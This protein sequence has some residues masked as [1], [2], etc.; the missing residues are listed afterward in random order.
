MRLFCRLAALCCW[1]VVATGTATLV[2]ADPLDWP[3]WRGPNHNGTSQETGLIDSWDPETGENVVWTR[4]DLSARSTPIVMNGK[5]YIQTRANPAT[6]IEGERVVCLDAATGKTLWENTFG[7]Y[8]SDVPDTRVGWPSVTGDPETG[9]VYAQGVCGVFL[10]IDGETGKTL[11]SR[12]MHEEFGLLSTYGGRTNTPVVFEDLVIASGVMIGWREFAVPAHRF[13]AFDKRTGEI[14]WTNG[15]ALSPP[16]T[17]YSMPVICKLAGQDA[18]V[19]GSSDGGVHAFQPRTGKEIWKYG[20]SRRGLN[21]TPTVHDGVVYIGH[22]EE[23]WNEND[24]TMGSI[25]AIDGTLRG[26]IT[27]NGAKWRHTEVV[28]GRSSPLVIDDKVYLIDDRGGL[29]IFDAETGKQP[30]LKGSRARYDMK[31]GRGMFG[32]PLYADG[33]I[34]LCTTSGEWWILKPDPKKGVEVVQ[35]MLRLNTEVNGSPIVSH[36][37]IYLATGDAIYCLGK[38]DAPAAQQAAA[39]D[40][41][42]DTKPQDQTPAHVQVS[43]ADVLLAP[44]QS[45]KFTVR[46]YNAAGELLGESKAD[47]SVDRG[48]SVKA[49]GTYTADKDYTHQASVV[50]AKVGDLSGSARIRVIGDLPW[51]F[52]FSDGRV[53]EVWVGMRNRHIVVDFDLVTSLRASDHM[54]HELYLYFSKAFLDSGRSSLSYTATSRPTPFLSMLKFLN[55]HGQVNTQPDAQSRLNDALDRLVQ[56]KVLA[57]YEWVG[58]DDAPGLAVEK[59]PRQIEN[60]VAI[61]LDRIPIPSGFTQLGTR[62][63]G[64]M[65]PIDLHDYTV[66]ADF[67]G[68]EQDGKL[69]SFG[70]NNQRYQVELNGPS[71]ILEIRTWFAQKRMANSAP[72]QW[73]ANTWYRIKMQSE[74]LDDRVVLRAKVWPRDSEEPAEWTVTAEDLAP[75]RIGAPGFWGTAQET[76]YYLDNVKVYKNP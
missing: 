11:W 36:G 60:A 18:M 64:W 53:P 22:G 66:E 7:V 14:R 42:D 72:Y 46:L 59:G 62:S 29:W 2:A 76:E 27:A 45:Q 28:A 34:Y 38:K 54:A 13:V 4:N 37:K 30:F 12:S 69:P 51:S 48:G 41:G 21:V 58:E 20:F 10:C 23:Q 9:N 43:P 67:Y 32:S 3:N 1:L 50:T 70:L 49:D 68:T 5:L 55:L 47:F 40:S 73:K 74:N 65:G 6:K 63:Q 25:V 31:V 71:Q 61:K 19:F 16:D 52:D 57:S 39:R 44:G 24:N 15:T 26:D 75:Q 17:T 56:E 35:R 8:L 33:K